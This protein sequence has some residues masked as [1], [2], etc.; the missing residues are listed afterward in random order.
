ML[1]GKKNKYSNKNYPTIAQFSLKNIKK[2]TRQ[3]LLDGLD[4]EDPKSSL[5]GEELLYLKL[6]QN[7]CHYQ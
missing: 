3:R 7:M 4:H 5:E 6:L 1:I 2:K